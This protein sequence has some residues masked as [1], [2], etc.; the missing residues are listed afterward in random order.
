MPYKFVKKLK[1]QEWIHEYSTNPYCCGC[2]PFAELAL[3]TVGLPAACDELDLDKF[4]GN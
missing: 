3:D 4:V 2:V 1:Q